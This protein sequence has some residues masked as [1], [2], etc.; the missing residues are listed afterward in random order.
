MDESDFV[1]QKDVLKRY[2]GSGGTVVIPEGVK[3]IGDYA[4]REEYDLT[5][6]TFPESLQKI[7]SWAFE[8]CGILEVTFPEGDRKSVV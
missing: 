8:D 7:G 6:V 1:I 2:K 4:F 5:A 3:K